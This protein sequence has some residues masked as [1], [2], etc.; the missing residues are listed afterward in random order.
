[1]GI[2]KEML[3]SKI[4]E[5]IVFTPEKAASELI[6]ILP[7]NIWN[8]DTKF[9][10]IACKSGAFLQVIYN[11]LMEDLRGEIENPV[12]RRDHI[13]NNQIY[14]ICLS[15]FCE[16]VAQRRLYGEMGIGN[17]IKYIDNYE[18]L[19]KGELRNYKSTI[20][21]MFKDMK[22][23]VVIG[24]PPY[25][26]GMDLDFVDK[27]FDICT[28]YCAMI[29]PAKWKT[30]DK[31]QKVASKTVN[32]KDFR[33]KLMPHM[34]KV[35]FYPSSRDV[36]E[37]D[38]VDGISY[39]ILDKTRKIDKA[40]IEN[41]SSHFNLLND[42]RERKITVDSV[43]LNKG[44]DIIDTVE[45]GGTTPKIKFNGVNKNKKYCVYCTEMGPGPLH[46]STPEQP[47]F[48]TSLKTITEMDNF[49][50]KEH[51][52]IIFTSDSK[53]ECESFV[54]YIDT[55]LA[56]FLYLVNIS[57]LTTIYTDNCFKFVPKPKSGKF[58]HIYTDEEVYT[59]FGLNKEQIELIDTIIKGR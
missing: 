18:E 25:N 29:T 53:D 27:G 33:D 46:W 37:I 23:D 32:Y 52:V 3:E 30:A 35:V 44:Q 47:T 17:N 41:R 21:R 12:E 9:I 51:R 40:I 38:Q 28:K 31:D 39:Y 43:L 2:V 15:D 14:G 58:D 22:F 34:G 59:D 56:R 36:F 19:V 10:D 13:L 1:M 45:K 5:N 26:R 20:E 8:K 6:E 11:K 55:K 54:S 49:E 57:K 48:I 16:A 4:N 42:V 50:P 24:N 7:N